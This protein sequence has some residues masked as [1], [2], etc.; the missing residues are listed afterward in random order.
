MIELRNVQKQF[1]RR[2]AVKDLSLTVNAGE[3]FGLPGH[4]GAGKSTAQLLPHAT[5]S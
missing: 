1:S 4:N 5:L 3:I 2:W